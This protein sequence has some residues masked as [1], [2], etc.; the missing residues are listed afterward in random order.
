MSDSL[1]VLQPIRW[2]CVEYAIH[3]ERDVH[4]ASFIKIL[5]VTDLAQKLLFLRAF[6]YLYAHL[7][8]Y[9]CKEIAISVRI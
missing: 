5:Y 1:L 3:H 6:S 4:G 8:S 7:F 9:L 2:R